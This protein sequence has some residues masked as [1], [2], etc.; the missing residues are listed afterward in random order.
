MQK[1]TYTKRQRAEQ[2]AKTRERIVVAAV[3]LHGEIG[4]RDTTISA[5]AARAGVQRLTVYRH[6]PDDHALFRACTAHW[7]D[8]NPPPDP[9]G[10]CNER[11]A[12]RR[13]RVA[14]A[15]LYAYYR[16]SGEMLRLA[17]RDRDDL[18]ALQGPMR[19]LEEYL[20]GIRQD[21]FEAWRP[22]RSKAAAIRAV[23]GHCLQYPAW[24]S[25]SS[26]GLSD[27][28]MADLASAWVQCIAA[29]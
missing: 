28:Q 20:D 10:W 2:E 25:L 4:P 24:R 7:L 26:E 16:R 23:L 19:G 21:L 1:R 6:F 5:I 27:T 18:P 17:Y 14:L 29:A 13:T 15:A 22:G 8:A 9:S 12:E 11:D 3:E